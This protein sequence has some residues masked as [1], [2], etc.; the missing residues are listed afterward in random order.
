VFF[1]SLVATPPVKPGGRSPRFS[2]PA[3]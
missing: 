3:S 1:V 2:A